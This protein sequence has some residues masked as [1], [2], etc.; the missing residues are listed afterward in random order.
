MDDRTRAFIEKSTLL[1]IASRNEKGAMD[2]SPRGGQPS[3]LR[4]RPDGRLLLPDYVGNR[5][6]DTIGNVLSNPD[7]ALVLIN[8]RC[9]D[10]L[11]TPHARPCRRTPRTSP[12]F[13]PT[14]TA[15]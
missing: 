14:R 2:V 3:V 8:R 12:P 10:Y 5:R 15:R 6:L 1:F 9:H 4:L 7:V 13:P 11:R